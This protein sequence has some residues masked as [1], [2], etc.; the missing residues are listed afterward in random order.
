VK[1]SLLQ[2]DLQFIPKN[3]I[4]QGASLHLVEGT[5]ASKDTVVSVC[6]VLKPWLKST[7][8]WT[9]QPPVGSPISHYKALG[10]KDSECLWDVTVL[11][12][13]W[14]HNSDKNFGLCL[15]HLDETQLEHAFSSSDSNN[16]P[17]LTIHVEPS[18][19]QS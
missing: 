4:V 8:N 19:L 14:V 5:V 9:N 13:F 12:Q 7:I 3:S 1:R 15:K 18:S 2:F 10:K 11:V 17:I 16:P 6:E